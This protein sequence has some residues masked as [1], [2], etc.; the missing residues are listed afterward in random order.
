M[1]I[2]ELYAKLAEQ[3]SNDEAAI[4]INQIGTAIFLSEN[5][6]KMAQMA[7]GEIKSIIPDFKTAHPLVRE[8]ARKF[9]EQLFS[10]R[11]NKLFYTTLLSMMMHGQLGMI[12][13]IAEKYSAVREYVDDN[14]EISKFVKRCK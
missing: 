12:D 10:F 1:G 7:A 8:D 9:L 11:Q 5:C 2:D 4:I 14:L 6:N 3:T 13:T